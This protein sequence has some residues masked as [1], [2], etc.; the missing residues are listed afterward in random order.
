MKTVR[1]LSFRTPAKALPLAAVAFAVSAVLVP[2]GARAQTQSAGDRA[3]PAVERYNRTAKGA[4]VEEWKRR[5]GDPEVRT[6]LDAVDSLGSKGGNDAIRPLIEATADADYRVRTRAIDFLGTLR[7]LEAS[8]MLMQLLFLSD[9]GREEKLRALTA[10]G[11]IAD[12]ATVDP[13]LAYARTIDDND[14]A[15]RAV[16]ALGE[17]A[18]SKSKEKLAALHGSRPGTEIDRLVDDALVKIEQREKARPIEQPTLLE[19]EKKM[20]RA[21]E[22]QQPR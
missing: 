11:R 6:R 17:I 8:P 5:L 10:L 15:C 14:L 12:P 19:L 4:N 22:A 16:Y 9:V 13:L 2:T 7:A 18:G 21:Q 1:T 3:H 20:A